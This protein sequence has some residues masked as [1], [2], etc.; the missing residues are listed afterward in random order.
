M[1][2]VFGGPSIRIGRFFGIPVE[3]NISWFI[4]FALVAASLAFGYF[5]AAMSKE[6]VWVDVVAGVVTALLFFASIVM[7]ELSHS[8]V[9]RLGGL[10]VSRVT[11][12]LFGGVS[13]LDEEP[14]TPGKELVMAAAGPGM[15]LLLAGVLLVLYGLLVRLG[16]PEWIWVPVGYLA[17]INFI[18][19]AFNLTPGF[20]MDG[21][22]V[23]RAILWRASGDQLKATRWAARTGQT[24]GYVMIAFGVYGILVLHT[25][26]YVWF[27]FLGWFLSTL[28]G[29]AYQQQL[30]RSQLAGTRV[31]QVMASP[32]VVAPG[33]IDLER[34]V[35]EYFLGGRHSRYPIQ[36]DG[37]LVG[38]VSLSQAK[39]VPRE[40][41]GETRAI[42][43]ADR[44]LARMLVPSDAEVDDILP[45]LSPGGPG[46]LLVMSEGRLAGIVTRADIVHAL[47]VLGPR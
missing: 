41:W 28:A 22:R 12:F 44:D 2:D 40:R 20:P 16:A 21:G 47:Q 24:I 30:I 35:E 43:I 23:L 15:S 38:M 3:L 18:V 25:F 36:V 34:M 42:D 14:A 33:D 27:A 39:A 1:W 32:V 7:H 13:E 9:A 31:E 4:V 26:D 6:P 10:H 45:R 8:L 19:G 46:A 17:V 37:E 29:Q 11:L 5:P